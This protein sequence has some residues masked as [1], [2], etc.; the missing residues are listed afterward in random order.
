MLVASVDGNR[1]FSPVGILAGFVDCGGV[2]GAFQ[3]RYLV[4]GLCVKEVKFHN[5]CDSLS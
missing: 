3:L 2:T 1:V 5:F 4:T